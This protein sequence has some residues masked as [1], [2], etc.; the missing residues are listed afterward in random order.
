MAN[1]KRQRRNFGSVRQLPSGRW[2]LRYR[3]PE[4]GQLRPAEKTYAT[5]TDAQVT[6]MH[7]GSDMARGQWSDPDAGELNF[8]DYAT[9]WLRDRKL[10]DRTRERN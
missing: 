9:A 10:A 4:T 7:I 3:D 2:Q 8:A 1:K 6:L 5:K